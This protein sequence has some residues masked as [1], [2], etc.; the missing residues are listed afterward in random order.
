MV[1]KKATRS[2]GVVFVSTTP[3]TG[4]HS[5]CFMPALS[6]VLSILDN[7][8]HHF[9]AISTPDASLPVLEDLITLIHAVPLPKNRAAAHSRYPTRYFTLTRIR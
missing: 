5:A 4:C 6:L 3:P 2:Q 8:Q 9:M 7:I 1:S